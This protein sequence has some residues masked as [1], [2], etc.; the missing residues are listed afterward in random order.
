MI[1]FSYMQEINPLGT[2]TSFQEPIKRMNVMTI[3]IVIQG[4]IGLQVI[5]YEWNIE[6]IASIRLPL[7]PARN[8][9]PNLGQV[10]DTQ[11]MK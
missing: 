3:L 6:I 5:Y 7:L 4:G 9:N 1:I 10:G 8:G 2:E 11:K